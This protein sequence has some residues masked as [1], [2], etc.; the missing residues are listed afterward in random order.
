MMAF[1]NVGF[2]RSV[3]G[4][5]YL[6]CADCEYG[7]IGYLDSETSLHFISPTRLKYKE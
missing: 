3:E 6:I 1:E 2:T 7:P 5:K 4:I